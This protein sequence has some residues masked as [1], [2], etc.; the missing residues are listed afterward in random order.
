M[1]TPTFIKQAIE[2]AASNMATRAYPL[3]AQDERGYNVELDKAAED[4][5]PVICY[6]LEQRG[7]YVLT[8]ND[9]AYMQ[10][11]ATLLFMSLCDPTR[12]DALDKI[13]QMHL[14][15][16]EFLQRFQRLQAFIDGG[17]EF[18]DGPTFQ[19]RAFIFDQQ[20]AGVQVDFTVLLDPQIPTPSCF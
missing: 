11:S 5:M 3:Y 20:L 4:A 1:N 7:Q 17:A 10:Y 18:I 19:E 14:V 15:A 12:E 16:V 2:Q 9:K 8:G 6:D 13:G